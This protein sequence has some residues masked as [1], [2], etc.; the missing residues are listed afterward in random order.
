[1]KN[2]NVLTEYIQ[3]EIIWEEKNYEHA[4]FAGKSINELKRIQERIDYLKETYRQIEDRYE[5]SQQNDFSISD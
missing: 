2:E 5:N 3:N 4:L 1:M